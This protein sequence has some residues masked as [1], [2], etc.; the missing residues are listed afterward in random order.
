MIFV[1]VGLEKFSFS[2]LIR[3]VDSLAR[4]DILKEEVFMQIGSGDYVPQHCSW[5]EKMSFALFI[6]R[7]ESCRIVISHAGVGTIL[8]SIQN[9]KIPIVIPRLKRFKEAVDDHQLDL[10][11][12]L[13]KSNAII[14]LYDMRDLE[15]Y[16]KQYDQI[17]STK[18]LEIGNV[19]YL[20][21]YLE[22]I[23]SRKRS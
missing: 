17:I 5:K 1:T 8:L 3:A 19:D 22:H 16:I 18:K 7:L 21:N 15:V 2:R 12:E 20:N 6:R 23:F 10:V 11:R 14:P 13:D 4:R 9:N